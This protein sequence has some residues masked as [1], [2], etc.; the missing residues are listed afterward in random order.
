MSNDQINDKYVSE[1]NEQPERWYVMLG[2]KSKT[3]SVSYVDHLVDIGKVR[4][5][6]PH[7][8]QEIYKYYNNKMINDDTILLKEGD[9]E[10]KPYAKHDIGGNKKNII[11]YNKKI[12]EIKDSMVSTRTRRSIYSCLKNNII[13]AISSI[14]F[15]MICIFGYGYYSNRPEQIYNKIKDGVVLITSDYSV[16]SHQSLGSGF[17]VSNDGLLV[18]NF[19]V[20]SDL[21]AV[22]IKAG[23]GRICEAEGVV[24]ID[25]INDVAVLKIKEKENQSFMPLKLGNPENLKIGE[26]IYAIGN[27]AGMEFSLSE[28]IVSGKRNNDPVTKQERE[29]IQISAPISPGNSGG[30]ILDK[31]GLVVGIATLGSRNEFQNINFA[32]PINKTGDFSKYTDIKYRFISSNP[33]WVT[34]RLDYSQP[35]KQYGGDS[36]LHLVNAAYDQKSITK[37]GSNRRVWFKTQMVMSSGYIDHSRNIITLVELDCAKRL[38][39][40][41]IIIGWEDED[42]STSRSKFFENPDWEKF[43]SDD[44]DLLEEIC[45][46]N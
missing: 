20:I 4:V 19:H 44:K 29:L 18:T 1:N 5:K 45:Q 21:N 16:G 37:L 25:Q 30:P 22:Y 6:G 15:V 39:R 35:V 11:T 8:T 7:T 27:P 43:D 10:W 17:L 38:F 40:H 42:E 33:D 3:F 32:V 9:S 41:N 31:K 13:V 12:L 26:T 23:D 24:Y 36:E 2:E 14:I 46:S 28:G 34:L